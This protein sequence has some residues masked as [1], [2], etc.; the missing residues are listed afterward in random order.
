MVIDI[1]IIMLLFALAFL[2]YVKGFIVGILN[3]IFLVIYTYFASDILNWLLIVFKDST[4]SK[5][6]MSNDTLRY[7]VIVVVGLILGLIVNL[8]LRK[9]IKKSILSGF[10]KVGGILIHVIVG[11]LL[12]C[13]VLVVYHTIS[14]YIDTPDILKN[15]YFF[16]QSFEDYNIIARWWL[17]GN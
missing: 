7:F 11:Y 17:N 14:P 8:I 13:V 16:S 4:I 15:S 5:D 10:D 1:I 2:G 12:L 6:I 3:L 9:I